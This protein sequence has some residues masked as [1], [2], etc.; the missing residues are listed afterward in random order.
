M[1]KG[2]CNTELVD[3]DEKQMQKMVINELRNYRALKV[4]VDNQREQREHGVDLFPSLQTANGLKNLNNSEELR[5]KQMERALNACLD[6]TERTIVER[7]FLSS[8][9]I[10]DLTIYSEFG[11]KK[12]KYYEK[13][14][15]AML[16]L[17]TAI[18][19]I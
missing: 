9:E 4:K 5:V 15:S 17:A 16:R 7:K 19:I 2:N 14:R 13:K 1:R 3:I 10:N 18:G 12:G 11:I 6:E 8:I